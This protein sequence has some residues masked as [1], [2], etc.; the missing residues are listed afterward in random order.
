[1]RVAFLGF[2]LIGGSIARAIRE[3]GPRADWTLNAWS[4]TGD[5]PRAAA[6][7]GT[8]D[9]AASSA[10]EAIEGAELIV[11]AAPPEAC[12]RLIDDLASGVRDTLSPEAVVTDVASTKAAIVDRA[13]AHGLR[14]V[15]GHP[16]AGL[17]TGG[18]AAADG[19]LLAGR[20]WVVVPGDDAATERVETLA[21]AT[22]AVPTR[23]AARA[24]DEAAAGISHLPLVL[25]AALVETVAGGV[26]V[27]P[28]WEAAE[29]LAAGGW[30]SMTRL[31]RG[32]VEMGTGIVA[33]NADAL[34]RRIRDVRD[35][36]DGWL[37]DI[38]RPGGPDRARIESRLTAA[39][40][41][42]GGGE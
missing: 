15:G 13:T 29:P 2:G 26:E 9:Q 24:H 18:Y 37:V 12:L 14:F 1:V 6:T 38:E 39:R 34:A 5:G 11:L 28:G 21:R 8:I 4:P 36:L 23:M 17:E 31:A 16:M 3:R 25:S 27:R 22:G 10:A 33:T 35:A 30:A 20:P 42:L 40:A 32:D 41:R 7:D 19:S